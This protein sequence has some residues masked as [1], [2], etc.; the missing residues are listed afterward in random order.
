[1]KNVIITSATRTAVGS[2]NKSLKNVP[3]YE[4]GSAVIKESINRS[5]LKNDEVDEVIPMCLKEGVLF[6]LEGVINGHYGKSKDKKN[7]IIQN[8]SFYILH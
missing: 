2:L 1:M 7:K 8:L 6:Q 3:G 5:N 4:L